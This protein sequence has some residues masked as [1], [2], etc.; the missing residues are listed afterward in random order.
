M[1]MESNDKLIGKVIGSHLTEEQLMP[2]PAITTMDT[3]VMG[4]KDGLYQAN[5]LILSVWSEMT[6]A[7]NPDMDKFF[8]EVSKRVE[9]KRNEY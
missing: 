8:K 3:Y 9:A 2:K 4:L 1:N 5:G 6:G 7:S